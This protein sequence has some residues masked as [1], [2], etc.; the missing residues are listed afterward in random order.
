[1]IGKS[2]IGISFIKAVLFLSGCNAGHLTYKHTNLA[3]QFAK[4][5]KGGKVLAS[6]GTDWNG[7]SGCFGLGAWK[8]ES[9]GDK[10]WVK[11]WNK[12]TPKS[13]RQNEGWLVYQYKGGNLHVSKSL[14]RKLTLSQMLDKLK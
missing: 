13:T 7:G 10:T 4:N 9:K 2:D 6:D 5:V 14:G 3:S 1:M 12:K 8:Y 11:T